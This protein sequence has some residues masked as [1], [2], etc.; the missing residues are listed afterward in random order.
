MN[1]IIITILCFAGVMCSC[2]T[3]K[4]ASLE[5]RLRGKEYKYW[6][7]L[8]DY[9]S[10][11]DSRSEYDISCLYVCYF[12]KYGNYFDIYKHDKDNLKVEDDRDYDG[13]TDMVRSHTWLL[14][15]DSVLVLDG[16]DLLIEQLE[17]DLMIIKIPATNVYHL[18]IPA[19]NSLLPERYHR[20]QSVRR[21]GFEQS[22]V[23]TTEYVR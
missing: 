2:K 13:K 14:K 9:P 7:F 6:I 5:E 12:D 10:S 1:K 18:F 3:D 17:E 16:L 8:Q 22:S 15:N 20:L 4:T 23:D 21:S 19:P 11:K